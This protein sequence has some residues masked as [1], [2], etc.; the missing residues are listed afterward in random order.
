MGLDVVAGRGQLLESGPG[1][2][3]GGF[4][5]P[6]RARDDKPGYLEAVFLRHF[7]P[8]GME[9]GPVVVDGDGEGGEGVVFPSADHGPAGCA[10]PAPARDGF[11]GGGRGGG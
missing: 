2:P 6:N 5:F 8:P 7:Q 11:G 10:G 1:S 9:G 3:V 4:A